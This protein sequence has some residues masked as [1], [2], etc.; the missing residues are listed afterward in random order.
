MLILYSS[1]DIVSRNG[2]FILK[3]PLIVGIV[4]LVNGINVPDP[5][6]L[7]AMIESIFVK[8]TGIL[9]ISNSIRYL[10][11]L[12]IPSTILLQFTISTEYDLL[13]YIPLGNPFAPDL[14]ISNRVPV[15]EVVLGCAGT[16]LGFT[17]SF[18]VPVPP[19]HTYELFFIKSAIYGLFVVLGNIL[20][21]Y[22]RNS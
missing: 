14:D 19:V 18:V 20:P 13:K 22:V 17:L 21:M 15:V 5:S 12:Y 2:N 16:M 10:S 9:A 7:K 11:R 3:I 4:A 6:T 8:G 1:T